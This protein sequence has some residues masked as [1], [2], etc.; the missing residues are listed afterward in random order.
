M[1]SLFEQ[2]HNTLSPLFISSWD[3]SK[4]F[5]SLSKN[6]LRYSWIRLG[7][8]A[9]I[10]DLIVSVDEKGHTIIRTPYSQTLWNNHEY[11]GFK[12][13]R[14][15]FDAKRGAGQGDVGSPLNWV[16]AFDIL[17]CAL[18]SVEDGR[19]YI[20][21]HNDLLWSSDEIAYADDLVSA[22]STISGLQ[23]KA[24]IVSAYAII[25]GLDIA[26][27]K[28]RTFLHHPSGKKPNSSPQ[29]ITIHTSGWIP[30]H[31]RIATSGKLKALGKIY[32]ISS[33]DLHKTQYEETLLRAQKSCNILQRTRGSHKNLTMV[34]RTCVAKRVEYTGKFSSWGPQRL[35]AI[36][37][38]FSTLYKRLSNNIFSYPHDLLYLPLHMGGLDFHLTSDGIH[39]AKLSMLQRHLV[40]TEPIKMTI[41]TLLFHSYS[42]GTQT[43]PSHH[44]IT[45]SPPTITKFSPY[46]AD[47]ISQFTSQ[48]LLRLTRTGHIPPQSPFTPINFSSS[49]VNP[50]THMWMTQRHIHNIS[51]LF[52]NSPDTLNSSWHDFSRTPGA[53]IPETQTTL[54]PNVPVPIRPHQFWAPSTDSA[55]ND[56]SIVEIMG[57]SSLNPPIVNI[58]EWKISVPTEYIGTYGDAVCP[59]TRLLHGGA[60]SINLPLKEALG[61]HPR[62]V[63]LGKPPILSTNLRR[64]IDIVSTPTLYASPPFEHVPPSW[65]PQELLDNLPPLGEVDIFT[66]GSWSEAGTKWAHITHNSPTFTGTAGLVIISRSLDW[67]NLPILTMHISHGSLLDTNSAFS[68]ELLALLTALSIL[69]LTNSK[70]SILSDCQSVIRKLTKLL[71]SPTALRASARDISFLSA[72]L[73]Y[74][75]Q[76]GT[77][78]WIKG[79]P[80]RYEPD[81]SLWTR[82][83]WGN[84]L[85][86]RV[87]SG[88]ITSSTS[89]QY[90]K[91]SDY[92]FE[93]IPLPA[94]NA[95]SLSTSLLPP[96]FW[97]FGKEDGQIT[98][99]SILDA[100]KTQRLDSYIKKRDANRRLRDLP[101][102][103]STY[104]IP[105]MGTLWQLS[106]HPQSR[107]VRNRIIYDK[108]WHGGNIA[109]SL[110]DPT[111]II[112]Q[113]KCPL[114]HNADSAAH[115]ITECTTPRAVAI[116]T[117]T[118]KS[119]QSLIN[120]L[121]NSFPDHSHRIQGFGEDFLSFITGPNKSPDVW[122]GLWTT[123]QLNCLRRGGELAYFPYIAVTQLK[124]LFLQLGRK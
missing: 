35:A 41:N 15:Y 93:L 61:L 112:I 2:S 67:M 113:S 43:P 64:N 89:Y 34:A 71:S 85:A 109:K 22:T 28:L 81:E 52:S 40:G 108:H 123:G 118:I 119:L 78:Q 121:S 96:D 32:D 102:K 1:Q 29:R 111:Q 4:A 8:P 90:K 110:T 27:S 107:T 45:I 39:T 54:P 73:A 105:L 117:D 25:F 5:D 59:Q 13:T 24:D 30:T 104:N 63:F 53:N 68:M 46:W 66:D 62:R 86:D 106:A 69:H 84:H 48:G 87:A 31:I 70:A 124:K 55:A 14:Y 56:H 122:R 116:R 80:E 115:W 18:S 37:A 51:D 95:T 3:I 12:S 21:R 49:V 76:R 91:D 11:Q 50:S 26:T 44:P 58:R 99:G 97:Y 79:H 103:W 75:K 33:I 77:L 101:P 7:V 65:L 100:I 72:A 98:S 36:D 10:A 42:Q 6:T 19:F 38:A 9:Q 23:L 57:Y 83:M 94:Q 88:T 60:T 120:T 74:L 82:E 47:S 20:L 92:I 114:C 16:A 17:L